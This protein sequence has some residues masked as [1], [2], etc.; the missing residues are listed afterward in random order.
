MQRIVQAPAAAP[1][2]FERLES[3]GDATALV[4]RDRSI[5]YR[6]LSE[7]IRHWDAELAQ[8]AIGP[9]SVVILEGSAS[10]SAVGLLL[11]L[12]RRGAITVP[13]T[14]TAPVTREVIAKISEAAWHI[15]F[16]DAADGADNASI[17]GAAREV[18]TPLLQRLINAQ[19]PGLVLFSSGSTGTPKGVVHDCFAL[20]EKFARAGK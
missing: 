13:L 6:T 16:S 8:R 3:F 7:R 18:T 11:A 19:H 20:L 10:G 17:E 5:S 12:I 4:H 15:T 9:G 1:W 2:L 14:P